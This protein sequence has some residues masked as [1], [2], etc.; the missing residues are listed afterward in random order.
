M[1]RGNGQPESCLASCCYLCVEMKRRATRAEYVLLRPDP[2]HGQH[3]NNLRT[4]EKGRP[5]T[6]SG[7]PHSM[8]AQAPQT[9]TW[10]DKLGPLVGGRQSRRTLRSMAVEAQ[11]R[12]RPNQS[13]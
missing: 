12:S 2:S 7:A 3:L 13:P 10:M 11:E 9:E 5:N 8:Q 1:K 4:V 6:S